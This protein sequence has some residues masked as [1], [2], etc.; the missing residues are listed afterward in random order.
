M[1][2]S[3]W[4]GG[5]HG[6]LW[7]TGR[8][9]AGKNTARRRQER[10]VWTTRRRCQTR[11][12]DHLSSPTPPTHLATKLT[13]EI[14]LQKKTSAL[15]A[16]ATAS[17]TA[18][19][20][21]LAAGGREFVG[22]AS[23]SFSLTRYLPNVASYLRQPASP[24]PRCPPTAPHSTAPHSPASVASIPQCPVALPHSPKTTTAM[25]P[26]PPAGACREEGGRWGGWSV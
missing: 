15:A 17:H 19:C 16:K 22:T 1:C 21:P 18:S 25:T 24:G 3:G 4:E 2:D 14:P 13:E 11:T 9:R 8:E 10:Q 12:R 7:A 5:R 23:L 6:G 26:E 20:T